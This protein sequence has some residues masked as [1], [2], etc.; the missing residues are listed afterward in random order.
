MPAEMEAAQALWAGWSGRTGREGSRGVSDR[1]A[2]PLKP[3]KKVGQA[4]EGKDESGR[5]QGGIR[6]NH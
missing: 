3:G 5:E 4:L 6:F 1:C 2:L